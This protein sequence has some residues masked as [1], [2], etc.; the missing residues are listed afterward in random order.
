MKESDLL[1]RYALALQLVPDT[2]VAGDLYMRARSQQAMLRLA[3]R[4]RREQGLKPLSLPLEYPPLTEAE[5]EHLFHLA[6]RAARRRFLYAGGLAAG[7]LFLV[8]GA[9]MPLQGLGSQGEAASPIFAARPIVEALH[10]RGYP[11]K[12]H[13]VE[14]TPGSVTLWWSATG[15]KAREAAASLAPQ[16]ALDSAAGEWVEA[17]QNEVSAYRMNRVLGRSVFLTH[18]TMERH[19]LLRFGTPEERR[20]VAPMQLP[21]AWQ[22]DPDSNARSIEV[23]QTTGHGPLQIEIDRVVL[24]H[25][26]TLIRYRC[27]TPG[28]T[29]PSPHALETSGRRLNRIGKL[30][31]Q[32]DGYLQATFSALPP[33][34]TSLRLG[35]TPIYIAMPTLRYAVDEAERYSRSGDTATVVHEIGEIWGGAATGYFSDQAGLRYAATLSFQ[36][37]GTPARHRVMLR[38]DGLPPEAEVTHFTV[39]D[40]REIHSILIPVDLPPVAVI[41]E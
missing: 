19:V 41:E 32:E 7:L 38:A 31:P 13:Q 10:P 17:A 25:N 20:A 23:K 5:R 37:E 9:L 12:V 29:A 11:V 28:Y 39:N 30:V 22:P 16:L 4:W 21:L 24:G 36:I 14:A 18:P 33:D 40:L 15:G 2:D 3:N 1:E 26:Y 34:V 6:R 27:I 35:F 8:L